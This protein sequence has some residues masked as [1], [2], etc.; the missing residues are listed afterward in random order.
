MKNIVEI[1]GKE[2]IFIPK[3][4][5]QELTQGAEML[6]DIIAYDKA[7]SKFFEDEETFPLSLLERK[8][9][10]KENPILIYREHRNISQSQLAKK[11]SVS[12]QY[13]QQLE[14]GK[15]KGTTQILKKIAKALNVDIENLI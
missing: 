12:Q 10:N 13:I 8:F 4:Y 2:F 7:K 14:S 1:E 15:R 5:Y 11:A 6:A 3:E 9:I